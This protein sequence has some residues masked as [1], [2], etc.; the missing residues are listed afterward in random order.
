MKNNQQSYPAKGWTTYP[1]GTSANAQSEADIVPITD[2]VQGQEPSWA[3]I[4]G[5]KGYGTPGLSH[6]PP[7]GGSNSGA[8]VVGNSTSLSGNST[9]SGSSSGASASSTVPSGTGSAPAA[10]SN[11]TAAD[12][13]GEDCDDEEL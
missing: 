11:G 12:T 7:S 1:D 13:D 4:A 8:T 10:S 3:P 2:W 5:G 6:G 9:S